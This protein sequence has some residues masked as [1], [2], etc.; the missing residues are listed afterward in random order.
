MDM[1]H[2]FHVSPVAVVHGGHGPLG[3]WEI[4]ERHTT[5][6]FPNDRLVFL[7]P[8]DE[9]LK[10]TIE[11]NCHGL[12]DLE[13]NRGLEFCTAVGQP[14]AAELPC[15]LLDLI[16][17]GEAPNQPRPAL[18]RGMNKGKHAEGHD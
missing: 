13:R 11:E 15:S 8:A 3:V 2:N 18:R 9:S 16:I 1:R 5:V 4:P 12:M 14:S 6:V 17:S 10:M 7:D